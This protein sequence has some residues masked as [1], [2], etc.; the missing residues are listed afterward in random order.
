MI[1][2]QTDAVRGATVLPDGRILSWSWDKTLRL[3]FPDGSPSA[4][5]ES[6]SERVDGALVL[7]DGRILSWS[8]DHTLRLWRSD[9]TLLTTFIADDPITCAVVVQH[10]PLRIAVGDAAGRVYVLELVE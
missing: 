1:E 2:G 10:S 9:G 5:L 8:R 7:P 4:V 6:H 3:W